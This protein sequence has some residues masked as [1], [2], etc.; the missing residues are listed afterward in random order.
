MNKEALLGPSLEIYNKFSHIESYSHE[1][2][3][4]A[5]Y[6]ENKDVIPLWHKINF[7][8]IIIKFIT[9]FLT[10]GLEDKSREWK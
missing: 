9:L 1:N 3:N 2:Y 8:R 10:C 7:K 5:F 6:K 4:N